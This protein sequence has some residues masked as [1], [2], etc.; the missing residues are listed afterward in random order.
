MQHRN[1]VRSGTDIRR[2]YAQTS[3][4][5]KLKGEQAYPKPPHLPWQ[6]PGDGGSG[7]LANLSSDYTVRRCLRPEPPVHSSTLWILPHR[8]SAHAPPTCLLQPNFLLQ[9][10]GIFGH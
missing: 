8:D 9:F 7:Y 10:F 6:I 1:I 5:K 3:K 2:G 4:G